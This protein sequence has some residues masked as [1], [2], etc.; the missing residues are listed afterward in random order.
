[1]HIIIT[2]NKLLNEFVYI[3]QSNVQIL[4]ALNS[5]ILSFGK[6]SFCH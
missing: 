4:S 6:I 5:Q 1:M 2:C 3:F